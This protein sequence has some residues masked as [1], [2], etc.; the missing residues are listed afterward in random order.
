MAHKLETKI[1]ETFSALESTRTKLEDAK[2]N[3]NLSSIP[4]TFIPCLQEAMDKN[5]ETYKMI[6]NGF[7]VDNTTFA[8]A[9]LDVGYSTLKSTKISRFVTLLKIYY[10]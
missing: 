6:I 8:E 5:S 7:F 9:N 2:Y 10:S 1:V 3:M 4:S